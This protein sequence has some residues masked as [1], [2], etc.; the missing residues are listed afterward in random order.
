MVRAS[1]KI[2]FVVVDPINGPIAGTEAKSRENAWR[3]FLES[4]SFRAEDFDQAVREC[5]SDGF[6]VEMA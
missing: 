3:A 1:A 4:P 6:S 5:L 2:S